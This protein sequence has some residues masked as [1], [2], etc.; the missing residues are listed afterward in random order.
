[1]TGVKTVAT[2]VPTP[3][4]KPAAAVSALFARIAPWYDALNH[5]L[6][7]GIDRRWRARLA[8]ELALPSGSRVLDVAC[9]TGDLTLALAGVGHRALGVDFCL[10][11]LARARAKSARLAVAQGDALGLPLADGAVDGVTV[12]F[13]VRNFE[14][15]PRGLAE[16]QRVTKPGGS[17]AI[18]EFGIPTAPILRHAYLFYFRRLLPVVGRLL[19]RD[20][21]AYAY[22]RDSVLAF[23]HGAAFEAHLRAAGWEPTADVPLTFG[24]V[25]LYLARRP[26]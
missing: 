8:R 21:G 25:H 16:L 22:L 13:G 15:L 6:T 11:M 14:D 3:T 24:I 23:P 19:S 12:G 4:S 9:G 17:L 5:L 18:L 20:D 2:A 7:L 26:A 1:M 10:P